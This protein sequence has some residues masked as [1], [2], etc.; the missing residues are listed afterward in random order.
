L[1]FYWRWRWWN[2]IQ[3]FFLDIFYFKWRV[4]IF[5]R[6]DNPC[7]FKLFSITI[8]VILPS[9]HFFIQ[10]MICHKIYNM[11]ILKWIF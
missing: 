3:A 7:H 6:F 10:N 1:N 9:Y 4:C 8:L 2:G 11:L 5:A